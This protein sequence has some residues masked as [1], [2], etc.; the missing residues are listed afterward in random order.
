MEPTPD[1]GV[2]L[3][4]TTSLR[5][6]EDILT[7]ISRNRGRAGAVLAVNAP[8]I[9]ENT[10]GG[11]PADSLVVEHFSNN[12]ID[13]YQ[14]NTVNASHPRTIGRALMRMG[15]D[16]DPTA[17]GDRVIETYNRPTQIL[18][19]DLDR[20]IRLKTGPVGARKDAV[21]R[22]RELLADKLSDAVPELEPSPALNRLLRA[23]LPSSNGSRVGEL[24]D[25]LEAA[26]SAYVS[27]YLALRGPQDCAFLGDLESGYILLPTGRYPAN[28]GE[29]PE[30][31]E[32]DAVVYVDED[33]NELPPEDLEEIVYVDEDG[34]EIPAEDIGEGE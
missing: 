9:V 14:A 11:R 5:S 10:S 2:K 8:L 3:I 27:A 25:R 7:W 31:P 28:Y 15:F 34:N 6:H 13:D 24:E 32:E 20:P 18:L 17:E 33:G 4:S 30:A 12:Q 1:G 29:E 21:S 26:L 19:W 23:D 16:P 22:F